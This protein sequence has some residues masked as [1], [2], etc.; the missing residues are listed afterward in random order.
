EAVGHRPWLD[1]DGFP[2]G[3]ARG[4]GVREFRLDRVDAHVGLQA[5]H[6]GRDSGDEAA[7]ADLYERDVCVRDVLEH[8]QPGGALPG[9]RQR[10]ELVQN[11]AGLERACLLEEL[12]LEANRR[13]GLLRERSRRQ[14]RRAVQPSV[15]PL[16][17]AV[18]VVERQE[19]LARGGHD[20]LYSGPEPPSGGVSRPPFAV[21]APHWTQFDAVTCTAP[22]VHSYTCAGHI[23]SHMRPSSSG[24]RDWT[25]IWLG[26]SSRVLFPD[27]KTDDSLSNVSF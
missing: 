21:M 20:S 11:A 18:H 13:T 23:R 7:A 14:H 24:T 22:S 3:H 6:G 2:G 12:G 1:R 9:A 10:R 17:G 8:L 16:A 27:A 19:R 25:R 5:L 26:W 4:E 15:D